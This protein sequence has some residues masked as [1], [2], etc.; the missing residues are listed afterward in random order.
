MYVVINLCLQAVV[1]SRN[2]PLPPLVDA[3]QLPG[4]HSGS[5]VEA[6]HVKLRS[7]DLCIRS[8]SSNEELWHAETMWRTGAE[9]GQGFG[10]DE[11]DDNGCFNRKF[12]RSSN[13]L[14][15]ED[16]QGNIV[17]ASIY[18]PSILSRGT[19]K[20]LAN[21]Y[22]AVSPTNQRQGI[23]SALIQFSLG[24]V[25]QQGYKGCVSDTFVNNHAGLELLR[26]HKYMFTGSMPMCAYVKGAGPIDSIIAYKQLT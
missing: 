8:A 12:F 21:C 4:L 11:F 22:V 20:S 19:D 17:G 7:G 14:V 25:K 18:G 1:D 13:V 5:Q 3:S 23:G 10:I 6:K 16:I 24:L 2:K 15:A 9:L 26:K